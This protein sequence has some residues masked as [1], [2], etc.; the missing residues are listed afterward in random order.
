MHIPDYVVGQS[1]RPSRNV[2]PFVCLSVCLWRSGMF[3]TDW[4]TS[5]IISR[6][7]SLVPAQIHPNMGYLVQRSKNRVIGAGS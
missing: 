7:N 1:V 5:K 6:P 3:F 4:N 2:R